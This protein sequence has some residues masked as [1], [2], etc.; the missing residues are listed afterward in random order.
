MGMGDLRFWIY[1]PTIN[2]IVFEEWEGG[3]ELG[4]WEYD[5]T[6]R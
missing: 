6:I 4:I 3:F 5:L 2:L 1:L